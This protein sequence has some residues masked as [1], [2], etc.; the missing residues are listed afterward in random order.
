MADT[1]GTYTIQEARDILNQ[2]SPDDIY[3]GKWM[4]NCRQMF[5]Q[6]ARL[7]VPVSIDIEEF[8]TLSE[9]KV[10]ELIRNRTISVL[11]DKLATLVGK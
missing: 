10:R 7:E 8:D 5:I 1:N 2:L 3:L 6:T 11:K 9:D 4:T